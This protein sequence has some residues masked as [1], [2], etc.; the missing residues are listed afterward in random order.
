MFIRRLSFFLYLLFSFYLSTGQ[1]IQ[2]QLA[3]EY[4]Q[5]EEF[6]KAKIVYQELA[7][8]KRYIAKINTN[9]LQVLFKTGEPKE[10]EKYFNQVVKWFPENSIYQ[11]DRIAYY[12]ERKEE[13]NYERRI[14]HLKEQ[15]GKSRFQLSLIAHQ[16]ANKRMY[17]E[18]VVF[19]LLARQA[20][21]TVSAY[22]LEVARIYSL[23]NEK[24]KM[25]DEYLTYAKENKQ[26]TV[27][28]KQ[29]FQNLL[30]NE[31]ELSYLQ[32]ALIQ[33]MQK[34]PTER[35]YP[36]LMVW[37][38]LQRKNFYGAF[39]QARALDKREQNKGNQSLRVGRIA[40]DNESWEDAI[41]I[42]TYLVK[43]H[44][45]TP[46]LSYYRKIL[47]EAKEGKITNTFPI[48]KVGIKNLLK[49]YRALYDELGSN[50]YTLEGL[51]NLAHLHAFYLGEIDTAAI[52][53]RHLISSPRVNKTLASKSKLDLGDI[54]ILRNN[55][56]EATLLYSQ[57]EKSHRDSPLAYEAKL[58]NARL[59]YFMGNFSLAKSH[60][61][62]LKRATTREISN[63][64]I[65]LT[66]LITDNTFL[67]STD[68]VM[69][70]FASIELMVFQHQ[71]QRA[72]QALQQ[73]LAKKKGHSI[74]DEVY[75]LLSKLA[76]QEG[77]FHEAIAYLEKIIFEFSFDILADDAAF[78][79]AE[80][81]DKNLGDTDAA[82]D[83]YQKFI[84]A[85]PGSM[86]TA[87]ARKRFRLLRGDF[88]T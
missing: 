32:N 44:H 6:Q 28:I 3:N 45:E 70:T 73:L 56:W 34:E 25:V 85:F 30:K 61:D 69:Q 49:E 86:Y 58:K 54:Y 76:I 75:W 19:F 21:G 74:S 13:K 47:I 57:V 78:K 46:N 17:A 48:D 11:V 51:R 40:M 52:V 33:R 43:T 8:D 7:K 15:F 18:S 37:V 50:N 68:V 12:F 62:I 39:L 77:N 23:L 64:A 14:N 38:E 83:L 5:K 60:L 20:S 72:K 42:F 41:I 88:G 31:E 24:Q 87:E 71:N 27:Y 82:Q 67:D 63:D 66:I 81:T 22:A 26:N 65:D 84:T 4:Y 10:V 29:I 53:L 1:E 9:Y 55:P 16:L 59:H 35:T 2:I 79:I 80:I 36:D